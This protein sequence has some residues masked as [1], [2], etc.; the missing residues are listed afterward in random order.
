M[1]DGG[2]TPQGRLPVFQRRDARARQVRMGK[3]SGR[4]SV[5]AAPEAAEGRE[6]PTRA[7][8]RQ[9]RTTKQARAMGLPTA[10]VDAVMARPKTMVARARRVQSRQLAVPKATLQPAQAEAIV[11]VPKV[12][13]R[14][15][16]QG[17]QV[18]AK[19]L[20]ARNRSSK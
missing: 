19:K 5:A 3:E 18:S 15:V 17:R 1:S 11:A 12:D 2:D 20:T 7:R 8:S 13:L 4:V 14:R 9:V 6:M 16:A 10:D